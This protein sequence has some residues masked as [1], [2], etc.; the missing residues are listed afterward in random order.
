MLIE[1]CDVRHART[2]AEPV[3]LLVTSTLDVNGRVRLGDFNARF[4]NIAL[5][6]DM[7]S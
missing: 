2:A 6:A 4:E 5:D 3:T 7:L 1:L